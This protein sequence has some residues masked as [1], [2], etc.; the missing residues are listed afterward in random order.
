MPEYYETAMPQSEIDL[1]SRGHESELDRGQWSDN[2]LRSAIRFQ[3][4]TPSAGRVPR[5]FKD[6]DFEIAS[7]DDSLMRLNAGAVANDDGAPARRSKVKPKA[8]AK[9]TKKAQKPQPLK[10]KLQDATGLVKSR[11][12]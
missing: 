1:R 9:K 3:A 10:K 5:Q 11:A 12:R 8:V 2:S 6:T 7:V 4:A